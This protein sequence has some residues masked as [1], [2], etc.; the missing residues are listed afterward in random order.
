[1][2]KIIDILMTLV[3]VI[4]MLSVSPEKLINGGEAPQGT[5]IVQSSVKAPWI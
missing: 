1:M 3:F 5:E 2:K 4:T